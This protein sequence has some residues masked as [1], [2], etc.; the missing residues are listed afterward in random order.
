MIDRQTLL[1][2]RWLYIPWAIAAIVFL[3]YFM[4]WRAGASEMKKAVGAW[5][6]DQREAGY[7]VSYGTLIAD[8]FPFFLRL[9]I[10]DAHIAAHG[11]WDWQTERLTIDALPYDLNRLI[12][13]TRSQ[14]RISVANY[15]DWRASL[16][17]MTK[18]AIGFSLRR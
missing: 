11:L 5:V 12:F 18:D 8:G 10:E 6:E 15:G 17:P 14:Q 4:L 16:S 7:N 2:R 3:G 13:S 1:R 9:H